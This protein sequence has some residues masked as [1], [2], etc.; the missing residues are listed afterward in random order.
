[1]NVGINDEIRPLCTRIDD[2]KFANTARVQSIG[3]FFGEFCDHGKIIPQFGVHGEERPTKKIS[4][5]AADQ[6][7]RIVAQDTPEQIAAQADSVTGRVLK[8]EE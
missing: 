3:Q 1:M 5:A 6:D 4:P 7:G 8:S 2:F